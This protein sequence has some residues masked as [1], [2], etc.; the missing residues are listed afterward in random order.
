MPDLVETELPE[1]EFVT[2]PTGSDSESDDDAPWGYKAD[3][4]PKK[5]PGRPG[6]SGGGI[7]SGARR[8]PSIK[9]EKLQEDIADK[10]TEYSAPVAFV[11]PLASGVLQDR[12]NRTSK[13]LVTLANRNPK[14][15]K[16][17][18]SLLGA[19]A[20]LELLILLPTALSVAVMVDYGRVAPDS[21]ISRRFGVE[22]QWLL[23]Y[24]ESAGGNVNGSPVTT[25]SGLFGANTA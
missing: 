11:S 21:A 14:F 9:L 18:D 13:A 15:R 8:T 20:L 19:D 3:G 4:T 17:L 1:I 6:G 25:R 16:A 2:V 12:A 24:Q 22:K 5:K 23:L 7:G 10:I